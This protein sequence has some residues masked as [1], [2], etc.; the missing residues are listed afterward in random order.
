[1]SELRIEKQQK[2]F[3]TPL[4]TFRVDGHEALNARLTED[5]A[6]WRAESEGIR[7]S[8]RRGWHSERT[9]FDRK[10]ASFLELCR[11]IRHAVSATIIGINKNLDR[12]NQ[13]I[14]LEGWVNVNGK[15]A[16]NV[17]HDHPHYLLSG[18]Y[19]ISTPTPGPAAAPMSGD[20]EFID[21]RGQALNPREGGLVLSTA[22][23]RVR[24][25]AGTMLV[26]PASLMHWVY[27]HEED[28]ERISIAFNM[29]LA[30]RRRG[31]DG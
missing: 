20:I 28:E 18:C 23:V 13:E 24:P 12:E 15:G 2:L 8:N 27:P 9:L 30:Q 22:K 26:F 17:P 5:I 10:E 11:H 16:L 4:I 21:P 7:S 14:R 29:V 31:T 1:M 6:R 19:Y 3:A 25:D